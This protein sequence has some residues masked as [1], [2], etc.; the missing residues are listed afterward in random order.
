[1][2]QVPAVPEWMAMTIETL[3]EAD[4]A[5]LI[6]GIHFMTEPTGRC[7]KVPGTGLGV[8]EII[9]RFKDIGNDRAAL[10]REFDWLS[11]EQLNTALAY[12]VSF[13]QEIDERIALE[14]EITPEYLRAK[15]GN[16]FIEWP[17]DGAD[18]R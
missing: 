11:E 16:R 2:K 4:K 9:I 5:R 10:S 17:R 7:A 12:Y 1:M 8:W 13:P 15:F 6:P 14:D 18:N 3:T